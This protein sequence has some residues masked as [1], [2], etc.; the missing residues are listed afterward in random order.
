MSSLA[1]GSAYGG[2]SGDLPRPTKRPKRPVT[3]T[4]CSR[5]S[6]EKA[7]LM[8]SSTTGCRQLDCVG[9]R[10]TRPKAI[11]LDGR[12]ELRRAR[13]VPRCR[14]RTASE[15]REV[16]LPTRSLK[17]DPLKDVSLHDPSAVIRVKTCETMTSPSAPWQPRRVDSVVDC[18]LPN[19][20]QRSGSG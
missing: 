4:T 17:E 8:L 7:E 14:M 6:V 3:R 15:G 1:P 20:T 18:W 12:P 9:S 10:F 19:F 16:A 5:T 13:L 2:T 11:L